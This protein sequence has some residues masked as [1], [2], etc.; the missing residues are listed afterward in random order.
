M[1]AAAEYAF[2]KDPFEGLFFM[3]IHRETRIFFEIKVY[4]KTK[5]LKI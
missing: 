1:K 5:P 4:G 3:L 2:S